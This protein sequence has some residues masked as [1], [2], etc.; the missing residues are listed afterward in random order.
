MQASSGPRNREVKALL[1][2]MDNTL[3]DFVTAK[4]AA[5]HAVVD[6]LKVG[7]GEDLYQYFRRPGVGFEDPENILDYI[8]DINA[9]ASS[10]PRCCTVYEKTK[11]A[12]IR[13]YEGAAETLASL[14][15]AG[16]PLAI[17]TDAHS[18]QAKR[19]LEKAG[20]SE[21]FSCI[22][23]PDISG[24]RKPDPASFLYALRA[25]P[26]DAAE[27]MV[28]GDSIRREIEPAQGL[29]MKTAYA[30]YG[31]RSDGPAP[32][33]CRPDFVLHDIR[34]LIEILGI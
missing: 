31:D 15:D 25:L 34:E 4:Q 17:V 28:V 1:F 27:A 22:V 12:A 29:G 3:W 14:S 8:R 32:L 11:L 10:F 13:P 26:A 23:T 5:C 9:P 7:D 20:L 16:I 33:I 19:R 18:S 6:F 2:D 24:Q 21:Y 30:L